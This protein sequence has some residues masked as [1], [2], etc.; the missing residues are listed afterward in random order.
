MSPG[1]IL[2]KM[3]PVRVMTGLL[4]DHLKRKT[5][6]QIFKMRFQNVTREF[7]TAITDCLIQCKDL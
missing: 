4:A 5:V 2:V 7:K 6:V 1:I 3:D